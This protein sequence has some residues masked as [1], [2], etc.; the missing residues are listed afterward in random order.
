MRYS[1]AVRLTA[2]LVF[3]GSFIPMMVMSILAVHNHHLHRHSTAIYV[4]MIILA[5]A[6]PIAVESAAAIIY[7]P[8][9]ITMIYAVFAY[10]LFATQIITT[11]Y[12][13]HLLCKRSRQFKSAG[14]SNGGSLRRSLKRIIFFSVAPCV[15]QVPFAIY[16]LIHQLF[17]HNSRSVTLSIWDMRLFGY[18]QLIFAIKPTID[19][20][21]TVF[22]LGEYRQH[23]GTAYKLMEPSFVKVFPSWATKSFSSKSSRASSTSSLSGMSVAATKKTKTIPHESSVIIKDRY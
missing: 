15:L 22:F 10:I 11:F 1:N 21:S 16:L 20:L 5:D 2:C 23:I 4:V 19:A 3:N 7:D 17:L 14:E 18:T 13:I 12:A 9:S 6:I 8:Y